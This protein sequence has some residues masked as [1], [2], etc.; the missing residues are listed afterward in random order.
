MLQ[1]E[2]YPPVN[3]N[4]YLRLSGRL[5]THTHV[6]LETAL[7]PLLEARPRT[8]VLDIAHLEYISSAGVRTLLR[9]RKALAPEGGQVLLLHPPPQIRKVIDLAR[10]VPLEAVFDT[11]DEA[12]AYLDRIQQ[13]VLDGD[14]DMPDDGTP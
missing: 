8:L 6:E 11:R 7:A 5:D 12:D 3:G 14:L 1:I 13:G 2:T 4:Q 9:A 10:A